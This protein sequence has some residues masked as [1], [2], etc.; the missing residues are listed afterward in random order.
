MTAVDDS[1]TVMVSVETS[2]VRADKRLN[3]VGETDDLRAVV[4]HNV[5]RAEPARPTAELTNR[6]ADPPVADSLA[7]S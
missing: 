7:Q 2:R 4:V 6:R 3:A 1:R 5:L